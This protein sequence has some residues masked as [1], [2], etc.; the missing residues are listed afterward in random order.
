MDKLIMLSVLTKSPQI[1]LNLRKDD[2]IKIARSMAN[3]PPIRSSSSQSNQSAPTPLT[4]QTRL[5]LRG[6][7]PVQIGMTITEAQQVTGQRFN[8]VESGG[9]PA[10]LYYETNAV[11]KV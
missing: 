8:Q 9:E 3:Q 4:S 6:F 2:L 11:E 1:F 7:G 10:C 5:T